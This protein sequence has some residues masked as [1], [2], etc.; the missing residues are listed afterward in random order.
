MPILVDAA[1]EEWWRGGVEVERGRGEELREER[2]QDTVEKIKEWKSGG[3][4]EWKRR[5]AEVKS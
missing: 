3:V 4:D 1:E 5:K 2:S